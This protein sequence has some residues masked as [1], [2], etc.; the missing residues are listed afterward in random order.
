MLLS[1]QTWT[2]GKEVWQNHPLFGWLK[3]GTLLWNMRSIKLSVDM[4]RSVI[5]HT[6][7][8]GQA[9]KLTERSWNSGDGIKEA[10]SWE[11][12]SCWCFHVLAVARV[13][14]DWTSKGTSYCQMIWAIN[15]EPPCLTVSTFLF[16]QLI[17][18]LHFFITSSSILRFLS[19]YSSSTTNIR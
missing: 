10:S 18:I 17:C 1:F 15:K 4:K 11:W 8:G 2:F 13:G 6:L 3:K 7:R 14:I 16:F 5:S 12:L 19:T 9:T